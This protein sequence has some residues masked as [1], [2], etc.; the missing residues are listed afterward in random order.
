LAM[1]CDLGPK[2]LGG[3][4]AKIGKAFDQPLVRK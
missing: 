4:F 1:I 2:L 3:F